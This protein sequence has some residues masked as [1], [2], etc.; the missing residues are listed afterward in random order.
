MH[1]I[2]GMAKP[3]IEE[4]NIKELQINEDFVEAFD[5]YHLN[6]LDTINELTEGIE[7]INELGK[8]YRHIHV[9]W[10]WLWQN[11]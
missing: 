8:A 4:K 7:E 9:S 1:K 11:P 5:L 2:A 10:K 3:G 6:D